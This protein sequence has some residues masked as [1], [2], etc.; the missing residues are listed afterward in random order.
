MPNA[1]LPTK[2]TKPPKPTHRH[3]SLVVVVAALVGLFIGW[4][5]ISLIVHAYTPH[6]QLRFDQSTPTTIQSRVSDLLSELELWEDLDVFVSFTQEPTDSH[7]I[8]LY[9]PVTGFYN[10]TSS[11]SAEE[12]STLQSNFDPNITPDLPTPESTEII[13]IPFSE[14]NA[15]L[16]LLAVDDQYFLETFNSGALFA[17]LEFSGQAAA[18]AQAYNL[19]QSL[20]LTIPTADTTLSFAQTGV[21]AL[22][23]GM[24]TKLQSV[25]D[26]SIYFTTNIADFLSSFDLT[27]TS[28]EASFTDLANASNICSDPAMLNVLT[29]IGLDI[30]ELTGNHNQDCGDEAALTTL[31]LYQSLGIR[32]VG[33]GA[34]ADIAAQPLTL[35]AKD[36]E[37][38]LLAY[39]LSTGGYTTND[40]PGANLYEEEKVVN[41]ITSAKARGDFIIVDVQYYECNEYANETEDTTCDYADS[42]AGD[43]IGLFRHLIDL[44]ADIVVGTAAHQ[45]Q[46]YEL[47]GDGIIYYG[48]GNLFF[49]QYWWPGTTRSLILAHYFW[50]GQHLQTRIIPTV[51]DANFQTSLL[52]TD[53]ATQ[54]LTRLNAARPQS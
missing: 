7:L 16:K 53:L 42:S 39:N 28:N 12:F 13:L 47:Y 26:D 51:F 37:I 23:R 14:L 15:D 50:Q 33:G 11:I 8:N 34:T 9:L 46:T 2:P 19:T 40:T 17:Y 25:N 29:S 35:S 32:T 41:D 6:G 3:L 48:L 22:S 24:Y 49:D 4:L 10:P 38:T 31:E 54:F 36:T 45:P 21:T 52:D 1:P 18:V 43:Q 30:V 5:S 20:T 44:G 27:H